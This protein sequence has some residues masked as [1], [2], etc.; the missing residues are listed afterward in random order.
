MA[1]TNPLFLAVLAASIAAEA[2]A[3]SE[4]IVTGTDICSEGPPPITFGPVERF[5]GI[6]FSFVDG[7]TFTPCAPGRRCDSRSDGN[8]LD[9][10]WEGAQPRLE[11]V[12][13]GWGYYRLRF[14][15]R[16][17]RRELSGTCSLA[18]AHYYVIDR[19]L[20]ARRIADR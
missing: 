7:V 15:G 6:M 19:V 2:S 5:D 17:A 13:N 12:W 14:E 3:Q 20:F 16:R 1:S 4:I 10:E 9:L 18:P 8:S 11:R